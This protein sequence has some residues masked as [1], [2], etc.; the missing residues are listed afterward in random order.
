MDNSSFR[1][2][3]LRVA[4]GRLNVPVDAPLENSLREA[5]KRSPDKGVAIGR[6]RGE[7]DRR[8][9]T[10]GDGLEALQRRRS[11]DEEEEEEEDEE[12]GAR[13]VGGG[14]GRTK[15]PARKRVSARKVW[16]QPLRGGT[17]HPAPAAAPRR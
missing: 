17:V 14:G 7:A 10:L 12:E 16:L 15:L 1:S 6:R 4:W 3:T 8:N 13:G 11:R 5:I 9:W 2:Q